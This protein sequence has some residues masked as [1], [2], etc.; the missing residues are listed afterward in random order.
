MNSIAHALDLEFTYIDATDFKTPSGRLTIDRIRD[1]VRW[2]RPRIDNRPTLPSEIP[3]PDYEKSETYIWNAFPFKWSEDV[4]KNKEDPFKE[5]LGVYGADY[6]DMD[7]PDEEWEKKNPL[8]DWT[9]EE[10][11]G[12]VMEA[13]VTNNQ[14]RQR[15]ITDA[16]F[17]CWHSHHRTVREIVRRSESLFVFGDCI[18]F[19]FLGLSFSFSYG[20]CISLSLVG[21]CLPPFLFSDLHLSF[22]SLTPPYLSLLGSTLTL[23]L[24]FTDLSAAIILEDDIDFEWN[25]EKLMTKQWPSLPDDWD[26]VY[27]GEEMLFFKFLSAS[28]FHILS[29]SPSSSVYIFICVCVRPCPVH[30]SSHQFPPLTP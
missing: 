8:P 14:N 17:S 12:K 19:V 3:I 27:L 20:D 13:S 26:I 29:L 22:S 25:I 21:D 28:S 6:W 24:I 16:G 2:Q 15:W 5:P 10:H 30:S 23:T 11:E 18:Y 4:E 7:P 1:R 9:K